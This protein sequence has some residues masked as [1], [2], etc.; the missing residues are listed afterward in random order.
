M[1][2]EI[3]SDKHK[4][5][6]S[7]EIDTAEKMAVMRERIARAKERDEEIMRTLKEI[8]AAQAQTNTLMALGN[9]RFDLIEEAQEDTSTRIMALENDKRSPVAI[10]IG[11][12]SGLGTTA[13]AIWLAIKGT[14]SGSGAP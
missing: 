2:E 1:T 3:G 4:R 7:A 11:V 9:Q 12:L 5:P 8:Q 10:V 14:N 13:T 6:S